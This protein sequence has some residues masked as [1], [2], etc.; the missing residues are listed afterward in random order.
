MKDYLEESGNIYLSY[1]IESADELGVKY[2]I[3]RKGVARFEHKDKHWYIVKPVTPLVNTPSKIL[4]SRKHLATSIL[5]KANLSVPIQKEVQNAQEAKDFFNKH[6]EIVIKPKQSLGG[7]GVSIKPK[8]EE[9]QGSFNRAYE[10]DKSK[11]EIKVLCEEYFSGVNVRLLTLSNNVI[12]AVKRGAP[13][14]TGDG[15]KTIKE[16]LQEE[17]QNRSKTTQIPIDEET[18]KVL[19]DQKF[20]LNSIPKNNAIVYIRYSTNLA[21]G[22]N[23]EECSEQIH[24]YYKEIAVK[25]IKELDMELGGVDL[26]VKDITKPDEYIINE[27]NHNPGLKMHYQV[28]KGKKVRVAIPIIK[29]LMQKH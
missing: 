15:G 23:T 18:E 26:I 4:A 19:K 21:Q 6:K 20:D 12:G 8:Y 2:E 25:A 11:D 13:E 1:Y 24:P 9:I 27:I 17:N 7:K 5:E 28:D 14:I 29:Y 3:L 10:K 22:G 16:I